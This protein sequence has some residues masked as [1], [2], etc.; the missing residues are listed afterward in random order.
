MRDFST[1][2]NL[3]LY[4]SSMSIETDMLELDRSSIGTL[5]L[6]IQNHNTV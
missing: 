4:N 3:I 1:A 2:G 6:G 5:S